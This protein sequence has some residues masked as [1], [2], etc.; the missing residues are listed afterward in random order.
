[1][2]K[3]ANF[4]PS[5]GTTSSAFIVENTEYSSNLNLKNRSI[6]TDDE[7]KNLIQEKEIIA[8]DEDETN[9]LIDLTC[10]TDIHISSSDG[11]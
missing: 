2:M 9:I 3:Q 7:V 1:M 4:E 8:A 11:S 5:L 10:E 6:I